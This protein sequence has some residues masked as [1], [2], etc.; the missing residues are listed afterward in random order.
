M[1]RMAAGTAAPAVI[2]ECA[3]KATAST[4]PWS[5]DTWCTFCYAYE[6]VAKGQFEASGADLHDLVGSLVGILYALFM[7]KILI[8]NEFL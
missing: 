4:G 6:G 5:C 7:C 2:V 1:V 3:L 8:K